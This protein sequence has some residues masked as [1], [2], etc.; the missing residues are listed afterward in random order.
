M[1][2]EL[3]TYSTQGV[4]MVGL[5]NAVSGLTR[6]HKGG[7]PLANIRNALLLEP[8]II[9]GEVFWATFFATK[10]R[11]FVVANTVAP[12]FVATINGALAI[13]LLLALVLQRRIRRRV[14]QRAVH[15]AGAG[16]A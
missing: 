10:G 3:N 13:L 11:H 7:S 12:D 15:A 2:D 9:V 8:G 1:H 14:E 16:A 4:A 6:R 5:G